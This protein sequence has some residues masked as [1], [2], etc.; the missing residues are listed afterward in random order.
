MVLPTLE[1]LTA[2]LDAATVGV[3]GDPI[4]YNGVAIMAFVDHTDR[5]EDFPGT[6]ITSQDIVIEAFKSEVPVVSKADVIEL[7]KTGKSYNPRDWKNN[8]SGTG[9]FIL[10]SLARS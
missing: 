3:L 1:S 6:Q 10:L 9:R 4:T 8:P 5:T 7:P 2:G